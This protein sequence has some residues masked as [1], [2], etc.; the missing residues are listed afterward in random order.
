MGQR[1]YKHKAT[2]VARRCHG[3]LRKRVRATSVWGKLI[4]QA[5]EP[6]RYSRSNKRAGCCSQGVKWRREA[7]RA[8]VPLRPCVSLPIARMRNSTTWLKHLLEERKRVL[9]WEKRSVHGAQVD[10]AVCWWTTQDRHHKRQRTQ[11]DERRQA[12]VERCSVVTHSV[13]ALPVGKGHK[14]R[15]EGGGMTLKRHDGCCGPLLLT[16][17]RVN[18]RHMRGTASSQRAARCA[19]TCCCC[20]RIRRRAN[21]GG[22]DGASGV[23]AKS[24]QR[25]KSLPSTAVVQLRDEM[26]KSEK[27]TPQNQKMSTRAGCARGGLHQEKRE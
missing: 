23:A 22:R 9:R 1:Q 24:Q 4:S 21:E 16:R 3:L 7:K 20:K 8:P 13:A 2:W 10:D 5:R 6:D 27:K 17:S 12:T 19:Q 18:C 14:A 26:M 15:K 25:R 11:I